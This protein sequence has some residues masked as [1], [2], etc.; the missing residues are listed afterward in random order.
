MALVDILA[1]YL[2]NGW[3]PLPTPPRSKKPVPAGFTGIY[4][5]DVTPEDIARWTA[6]AGPYASSA[7]PGDSNVALRMPDT[8]VGIDV[9][10]YDGK[11]GAQTLAII[12]DACG[13]LPP[14]WT[15]TSRGTEDSPTTSCIRFYRVPAGLSFRSVAGEAIE[16]IQ[17][18]HRY[19][20]VHPSVHPGGRVYRW[21]DPSGRRAETFPHIDQLPPLPPAWLEYLVIDAA[22]TPR[23]G[24]TEQGSGLVWALEQRGD[25]APC[26]ETTSLVYT[27]QQRM[28]ATGAG[29]RHDAMTSLTYRF[30]ATAAAGHPGWQ[31]ALAALRD[32]WCASVAGEGRDAEFDVMIDGAARKV[33]TEWPEGPSLAD[34]CRLAQLVSMDAPSA[35]LDLA[36]AWT[37]REL[38]ASVLAHTRG[39]VRY[40]TDAQ[41]WL[42][43][44]ASGEW[45][46]S[47]DL[48]SPEAGARVVLNK[49]LDDALHGDPTADANSDEGRRARNYRRLSMSAGA[50]AAA[51][52][53]VA[54]ARDP[55]YPHGLRM[56]DLD[57]EPTVL[58]AGGEAWDLSA[59]LGRLVRADLDPR[60]PHLKSAPYAPRL[61][62]TPLWDAFVASVFP[63]PGQ[64]EW[65]LTLL[66]STLHGAS[67]KTLIVFHGIA[68]TGKTALLTLVSDV[69]G[70]GE[71]GYATAADRRLLGDENHHASVL[72]QLAGRRFAWV[73]EGP[74][75]GRSSMERLKSL[76]GGGS[77]TANAMR[78][79]PVTFVPTHTFAMTTNDEP[80]VT[81][82]ALRSRLRL[83]TCTG[84]LRDIARTRGAIG[85]LASS[86]W[87]SEA[88]YVLGQL[89]TYT[90]RW[91]EDRSRGENPAGVAAQLET[92]A[93]EQD[94]VSLWVIERTTPD[95]WTS[96]AALYA[97]FRTFAREQGIPENRV[98][99]ANSFGR[100][101]S[102]LGVD[103]RRTT[104]GV[105]E[106]GLTARKY[107]G[108]GAAGSPLTPATF[109]VAQEPRAGARE[110]VTSPAPPVSVVTHSPVTQFP[111]THFSV[112]NLDTVKS[113]AHSV[114]E[115]EPYVPVKVTDNASL[116]TLSTGPVENASLDHSPLSGVGSEP[117]VTQVTDVDPISV[118]V[119][120][121]SKT[122]KYTGE[123]TRA[124]AR[125]RA[126]PSTMPEPASSTLPALVRRGVDG[127]ERIA[128]DQAQVLLASLAFDGVTID[129][130]TSGY[131]IGHPD[132]ALRTV[133][134]GC[135]E[136]AVVL[137]A[138]ASAHRDL[139]RAILD[140]VPE[141]TAHSASA[142]IVPT[143][144]A[145][146]IDTDTLW[147]KVADTAI[148]AALLPP[149]IAGDA[150]DALG[151]KPLALRVLG[152]DA[153]THHA[154]KARSELF[155]AHKWLTE[156][157]AT[158]PANRNGWAM[159]DKTG[160]VMV[161]YAA[162]DV[163]D[164]A[165]LKRVMMAHEHAPS[166]ALLKREQDAQR[167]T[168]R[169]T[170]RGLRLNRDLLA[171][172]TVDHEAEVLRLNG[173][174]A[175]YGIA[176]PNST[177]Q[178]GAALAAAGADLPRTKPSTRHPNGQP[179]TAKAVVDEIA[180]SGGP[181]AELAQ[182]V[183]EQRHHETLCKLFL[184]PFTV[185]VEHGDGRIRP[186]I[187]TLGAAATGRMSASRPN[188]QQLPRS[189]GVRAMVLADPGFVFVSA[190]F[191]SIEVR[192]AAWASSDY[193]LADMLR[194][195]L[196]L[197]S[198]IAEQVY[199]PAF[200]KAN[201]YHVKRAVFGRLYGQG[202]AGMSRALGITLTDAQAIIDTLDS[203]TPVLSAWSKGLSKAV[204]RGTATFW[205][206]H[207]G[208]RTWFPRTES[209]KAPNYV[210]QS[211]AR[212]LFVDALL[213][214]DEYLPGVLVI[215]VHDEVIL[216][217]PEGLADYAAQVLRYAMGRSLIMTDGSAIPVVIEPTEPSTF[218]QDAE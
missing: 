116:V 184:R 2:A 72:M 34:P 208:R 68:D 70:I 121:D 218:W 91:L 210:I 169:V 166:A 201:R 206:H 109:G 148:L 214:I 33:A 124:R 199:G 94:V 129:V 145:V 32:V 119:N 102:K 83:V 66:G 167:I 142:D 13:V 71:R 15:S 197:H 211:S 105:R 195:G 200:T 77:M 88:P 39:R 115:G 64:R 58:W 57:V 27:A 137:D 63:D 149:D 178:V 159:V 130:E 62:P 59:S 65:V 56:S 173:V 79:N 18:R 31:A 176:N 48:T 151:L 158:T 49:A 155:K 213:T 21:H 19:A 123:T 138:D 14:T 4:G 11:P 193:G 188:I 183:L 37:D 127:V 172:Q 29:G 168:A 104:G 3:N 164:T 126:I 5:A 82:E 212:E 215:P 92:M 139:V 209:H 85:D 117:V 205:E 216:M 157:D 147:P 55:D 84:D 118:Q 110:A 38:A 86:T 41:R 198:L 89:M 45:A 194:E 81:D 20:I 143:A 35:P 46:G 24:T 9:D 30:V 114:K 74:R 185:Q 60:T 75:K 144:L 160:D 128:L 99:T 182:L 103:K 170:E 165:A 25:T 203:M 171:D 96:A 80:E 120:L 16:V 111:V 133:Q 180:N 42:T 156:T 192:E 175:K 140:A 132:Y 101:L 217:V 76:T 73:D 44:S 93:A 153:Q 152:D 136:W 36:P 98:E 106:Y 196:D 69:L 162:S 95:G 87:R 131:P 186:T 100:A 6:S 107:R 204:E 50:S 134:L 108:P 51:S 189:G 177:A 207:S 187:Y 90:A 8:V 28:A 179:S 23:A 1:A 150:D 174:L 52:M 12:E 191:P 202:L 17:R 53:M 97:D 22:Q 146:G 112:T 154:D 113:E 43:L 61:G 190:D 7:W 125:A 141:V 10:D 47:L 161:T 67:P 135:A 122:E 54:Y 40:L 78:A 26:S 163:L 181:A